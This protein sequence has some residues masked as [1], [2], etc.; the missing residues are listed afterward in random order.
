MH[1]ASSFLT[2]CETLTGGQ[3]LAEIFDKAIR[4]LDEPIHW[5]G[6]HKAC[7]W[8]LSETPSGL[9]RCTIH[10]PCRINDLRATCV[11]V[12]GAVARACNN[13]GILPPFLIRYLDEWA[14]AYL[15]ARGQSGFGEAYSAWNTYDIG[16]FCELYG[17]DHAMNLLHE[18]YNK[19][20]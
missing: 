5:C 11:N 15:K 19:C 7:I 17:Y 6:L 16:W 13:L 2:Q 10:M 9:I 1:D 8:E 20:T 4:L 3:P 12:E 14:L 18:I